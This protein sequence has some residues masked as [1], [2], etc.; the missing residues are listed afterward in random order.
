MTSPFEC[1]K[2]PSGPESLPA[3]RY[4]GS[5]TMAHIG[6]HQILSIEEIQLDKSN[7]RIRKWIE[8]YG[9]NPTPEQIHLALGAGGDHVDGTSGTTYHSLKESIR[10]NGGIIHPILVNKD[11]NA[12]LIAIDGN[13]RVSIYKSFK[14]NN[15]DGNW[16]TIPAV[17]YGDLD[18]ESI[19]AIRL[20]AHLVGPR[21]W[22]P[23]SKAKYLSYLYSHQHMPF[24]RL[25]DYC[26]GRRKEVQEYIQAY[27]DMEHYYRP[28]VGSD[29]AFDTTRFSG[30]VELQRAVVKNAIAAAGFGLPDFARWI[31]DRLIDR[32]A[33]VRQLP[34]ILK[35]PEARETF[36]SEGAR[37]AIKVLERG[38]PTT[39]LDQATIEELCNVLARKLRN[40]SFKEVETLKEAPD[41]EKAQ[42]LLDLRDELDGIVTYVDAAAE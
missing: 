38:D 11:K 22:D 6:Q 40:I 30:F 7:P 24:E 3:P 9:E 37:E 32:L 26:G 1:C 8:H 19:D 35:D 39:A 10:S 13:T 33:D 5:G 2:N 34:A 15:V 21:A 16:D 28:V 25:I 17:V 31:N 27:N 14:E 20:Q 29:S 18:Q 4:V 23:Y 41:S 12:N 42:S 36:L